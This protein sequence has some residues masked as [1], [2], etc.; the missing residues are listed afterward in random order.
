ML[1]R[2]AA[3]VEES[4]TPRPCR[5]IAWC[6]C[7]RQLAALVSSLD[8]STCCYSY[9]LFCV[10]LR[11]VRRQGERGGERA[12]R[13]SAGP[14]SAP[15]LF[16]CC[17]R[18][19][20]Q[21]HTANERTDGGMNGRTRTQQDEWRQRE[22]GTGARGEKRQMTGV[23]ERKEIPFRL[24]QQCQLDDINKLFMWTD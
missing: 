4:R 19:T 16:L 2:A 3:V 9:L 18:H 7:V 5:S 8:S 14:S 12:E 13:R 11:C 17:S 24:T 23:A 1:S 21:R 10:S 15:L 22:R 20:I 6:R